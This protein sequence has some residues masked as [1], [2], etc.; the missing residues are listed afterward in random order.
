MCIK[1][2]FIRYLLAFIVLLLL[3]LILGPLALAAGAIA[4]PFFPVY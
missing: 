1:N 3:P 4:F 2:L